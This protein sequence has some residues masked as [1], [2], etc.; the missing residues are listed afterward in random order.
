MPLILRWDLYIKLL[1]VI[2][3]IRCFHTE[4]KE[5]LHYYCYYYYNL[6][7]HIKYGKA[8]KLNMF[9]SSLRHVF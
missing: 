4:F 7:F 8:Y 2:S 1:T 3:H 5:S 6:P 9:F